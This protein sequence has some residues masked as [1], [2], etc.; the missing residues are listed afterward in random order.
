RP[1]D[2]NL[3]LPPLYN[4]PYFLSVPIEHDIDVAL[5]VKLADMPVEEFQFLNPQMNRP[6]ILAAGT[7]QIL[8]PYDN[9]NRFVRE[10]PL[11]RGPLST[12]TTWVAPRSMKPAE[13]ARTA[14]MSED[15]LREVNHIPARVVIKSGS[16]LLVP[17]NGAVVDDVSISVADNATMV[18][19]SDAPPLRKVSLRAGKHDSVES[20]AHRYRI[21]TSQVAQWNDVGTGA[22]FAPGQTIVVYVAPK[23]HRGA[24]PS[25][26]HI[27]TN[28][29]GTRVAHSKHRKS[30][31]PAAAPGKTTKSAGAQKRVEIANN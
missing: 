19:S 30:T 16:T 12:W 24:A 1:A 22:R 15:D 4:H 17:R 29:H 21:S 23:G 31:Q 25:S 5:A 13:A 7:P 18:L 28:E 14:G 11:Y 27:A 9:A 20:I 26:T 3:Q 2:F 8:L 10:L 6:V